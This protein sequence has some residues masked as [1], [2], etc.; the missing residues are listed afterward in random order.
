M[1]GS[2]RK[3]PGKLGLPLKLKLRF[4]PIPLVIY[5]RKRRSMLPKSSGVMFYVN[6][7]NY[8][9]IWIHFLQFT[10]FYST[11]FRF[12]S[13]PPPS[14]GAACGLY[15]RPKI[16]PLMAFYNVNQLLFFRT[17]FMQIKVVV[18]CHAS[19]LPL[20]FAQSYNGNKT[21]YMCNAL[22]E[23][24]LTKYFIAWILHLNK[25]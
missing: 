11:V 16:C 6:I 23:Q 20:S 18:W 4:P 24:S 10:F 22:R 8:N 7:A 17:C 21:W 19:A 2:S 5:D 25:I 13:L 3:G 1:N 14:F 12:F 15:R 9:L